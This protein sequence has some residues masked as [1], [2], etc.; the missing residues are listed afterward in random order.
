MEVA[1]EVEM[2]VGGRLNGGGPLKTLHRYES[3]HNFLPTPQG[4]VRVFDQVMSPLPG[5]LP[6]GN[7]EFAKRGHVREQLV[8]DDL[9][10][11]PISLHQF[12]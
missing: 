3:G 2:I 9:V 11:R 12:S 6:A 5:C 8:G 1:F 7:S 4:L 10:R